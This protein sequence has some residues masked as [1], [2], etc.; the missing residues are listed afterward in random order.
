MFAAI[1]LSATIFD[2]VLFAWS[3]LGAAFGPLLLMRL[4]GRRVAPAWAL[5]AMWSGAIV[6]IVWYTWKPLGGA[7][8][9]LVP[10]FAVAAV[11]CLLGSRRTVA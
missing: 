1:N 3:A 9:E 5:L 6:T 10:A 8:Y 11:L 2:S 4:S 7:L